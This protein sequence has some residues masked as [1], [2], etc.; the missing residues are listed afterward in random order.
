[1]ADG[2][3]DVKVSLAAR[4]YQD[5]DPRNGFAKT[6]GRVSLRSSRLQ[7]LPPGDLKKW[8]IWRLDIAFFRAPAERDSSGAHRVR[9]SQAPAYG[10]SDAPVFFH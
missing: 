8:E 1:M 2:K 3:K 10:F 6:W 4:G 7:A 9:N 5:P